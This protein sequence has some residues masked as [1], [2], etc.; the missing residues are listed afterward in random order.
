M[1]QQHIYNGPDI[2]V[3]RSGALT[4][5]TTQPNY[6]DELKWMNQLEIYIVLHEDDSLR[7]SDTLLTAFYDSCFTSNMGKLM[8]MNDAFDDADKSFGDGDGEDY[9][10]T[11]NAITTSIIPEDALRDVL[12]IMLDRQLNTALLTDSNSYR[13]SAVLYAIF[14]DST[15]ESEEFKDYRFG[16]GE[17]STLE[18]IAAECPYEYGPAVFMARALLSEGDTIPYPYRNECEIPYSTGKWEG[19]N[20][21]QQEGDEAQAEIK[22][23]PNPASNSLTVEVPLQEGD[24]SYIEFW[25]TT[26]IRTKLYKINSVSSRLNLSEFAPGV[27][28]YTVYINQQLKKSGKQIIIRN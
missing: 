15:F 7:N 28:F 9:L 23:Y 26:G 21:S 3:H 2:K 1:T 27:Y 11:L 20:P 6:N 5:T 18:S 10:D 25:N 19:E 13:I 24:K 14:P 12:K 4:D 8:R 22:V 17:T 16:S